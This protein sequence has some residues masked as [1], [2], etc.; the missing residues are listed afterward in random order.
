VVFVENAPFAV[1]VVDLTPDGEQV[2]DVYVVSN[3]DILSRI[4]ETTAE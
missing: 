1:M 3:P 2:R 4:P